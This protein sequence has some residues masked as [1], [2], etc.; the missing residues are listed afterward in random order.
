MP[1]PC[2]FCPQELEENLHWGLNLQVENIFV[3]KCQAAFVKLTIHLFMSDNVE[4]KIFLSEMQGFHERVLLDNTF[5]LGQ[6]E[7]FYK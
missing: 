6:I 1:N 5:F 2:L 4:T 7:T 3:N